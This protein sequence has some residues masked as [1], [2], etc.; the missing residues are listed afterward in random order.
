MMQLS[1]RQDERPGSPVG[2][3]HSALLA[4]SLVLTILAAA[5]GAAWAQN[6]IVTENQL[7]GTPPSTWDITGYG[8]TILHYTWGRV[9]DEAV[10]R[11]K[12]RTVPMAAIQT[13]RSKSDQRIGG[14][15]GLL[16]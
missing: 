11:V 3:A 7:A 13:S 1:D 2:A 14:V 12:G 10:E 8:E 4:V 5:A 6:A 16:M 15:H 9:S